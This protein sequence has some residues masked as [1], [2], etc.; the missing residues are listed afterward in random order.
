[1]YAT[2]GT[3]KNINLRTEF[4]GEDERQGAFDLKI[5]APLTPELHAFLCTHVDAAVPIKDLKASALSEIK[6]VIEMENI[7]FTIG[8]HE[9]IGAKLNK[10]VGKF[11]GK[12]VA[13]MRVQSQIHHKGLIDDLND[14]TGEP[15]TIKIEELQGDLLAKDDVV[16][17]SSNEVDAM[18]DEAVQIVAIH[19]KCSISYIQRTLKIGYN[20]SARIVEAMELAGVISGI[21][22]SGKREVLVK[23]KADDSDQS[24]NLSPSP[25]AENVH[26]E[27]E[28][29]ISDK[30]DGDTKG[31]EQEEETTDSGEVHVEGN[32]DV[33]LTVEEIEQRKKEKEALLKRTK[34]NKPTTAAEDEIEIAKQ[35]IAELGGTKFGQGDDLLF[36]EI[37]DK[38]EAGRTLTTPQA[39]ALLEIHQRYSSMV[40]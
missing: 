2:Q 15:M 33:T 32:T 12:Q 5:E 4:K 20:R 29:N 23:S 31:A 25:N 36:Q 30:G 19:R 3:L 17:P 21:D 24:A 9:I 35:M 8:N 40:A 11:E 26:R 10:V 6:Y 1:M 18:Y 38:I 27:G 34:K 39:E 22:S 37:K 14:I 28:E 13:V 7:K 16:S